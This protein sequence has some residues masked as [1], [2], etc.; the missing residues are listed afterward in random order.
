MDKRNLEVSTVL[1]TLLKGVVSQA[2][3]Q[4][5]W[6]TIMEN[7]IQIEDYV[8]KIGLT[9]IVQ[10]QDGYAYLR[11]R[12]F[13]NE[14][15]EIPRLIPKR[16]LSFITS[17]MLVLLRKELIEL[18]K[19]GSDEKFTISKQEIIEKVC[20]YLK[21]TT[22]EAKQKKEIETN[23]KKIEEMGFLRSLKNS[24]TQYEILPLVRGFIDA[25]WLGELDGK[26][27]EYMDYNSMAEQQGEETDEFI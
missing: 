27:Q 20:P 24:D 11:Q 26:L 13:D 19:G 15:E 16:Q 10:E 6:N 12:K 8:S 5:L 22:D 18:S 3:Q 14:E 23:I 2:T 4:K 9:L 7:Q 1:V 25:K 17:L 21:T